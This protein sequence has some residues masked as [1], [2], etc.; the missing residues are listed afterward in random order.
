MRV[1]IRGNWANFVGT[2]YCHA[3]GSGYDNLREADEDAREYAYSCWEPEEHEEEDENGEVFFEDEGPD[4]WTEEYD[5]E[6]HDDYRSGGGSF[7]EDFE[8]MENAKILHI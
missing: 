7:V 4:Y 8:R 2:D 3:F 5:P 6:V 1:I